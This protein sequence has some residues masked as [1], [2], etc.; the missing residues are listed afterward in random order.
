MVK[1]LYG[2]FGFDKIDEDEQGNTI[3]GYENKCHVIKAEDN[4]SIQ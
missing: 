3:A 1:D 4:S 2:R